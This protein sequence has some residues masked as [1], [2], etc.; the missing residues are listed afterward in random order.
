VREEDDPDDDVRLPAAVS[1]P[2]GAVVPLPA[3]GPAAW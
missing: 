3:L 1:P 2:V